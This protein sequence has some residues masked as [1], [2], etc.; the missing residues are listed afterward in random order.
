MILPESVALAA[1]VIKTH[2]IHGEVVLATDSEAVAEAIVPGSCLVFD[3]DGILTPFFAGSVRRR[4]AESLLVAFDGYDSQQS[5][6]FFA[7]REAMLPVDDMPQEDELDEDAEGFYAGQ[8]IG[9]TAIDGSDDS[10]IG[11]IVDIDDQTINVLFVIER[12]DGETALIPVA[13]ELIAE[14]NVI[15]KKIIFNLPEGLI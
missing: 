13:D 1:R 14:L 6:A 4:G 7:G 2:G 15:D 5:A 10:V 8:L 3:I 9:F 11:E 12:G